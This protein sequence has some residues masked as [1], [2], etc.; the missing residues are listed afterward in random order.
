MM[1]NYHAIGQY[2]AG[3]DGLVLHFPHYQNNIQQVAYGLGGLPNEGMETMQAFQTA[4]IDRGPDDWF[5]IQRLA[6]QART[7]A[8]P[9]LLSLLRMSG[10]DGDLLLT[11]ER[12]LRRA[13][14]TAD[15]AWYP[16]VADLLLQISEQHLPLNEPDPIESVIDSLLKEMGLES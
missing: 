13:L 9:D 5:G 11:L 6:T 8:L 14:K 16:D 15:S 4:V 12:P 1:V 2:I 3:Q 7:M 10:G